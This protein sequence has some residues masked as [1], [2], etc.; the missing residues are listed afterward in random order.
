MEIIHEFVQTRK[1]MLGTKPT[2][3]SARLMKEKVKEIYEMCFR[4]ETAALQ[5]VFGEFRRAR[6]WHGGRPKGTY[7]Y[8]CRHLKETGYLSRPWLMPHKTED[9]MLWFSMSDM[10]SE[11]DEDI[12]E[13]VK[14][15]R[16]AE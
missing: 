10:E 3:M 12:V 7:C 6:H 5:I 15:S 16:E 13:E 1:E 14:R 11:D 8:K 4:G 2:D 9:R